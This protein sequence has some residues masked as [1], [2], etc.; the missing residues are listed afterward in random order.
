MSLHGLCT[1]A[2][3]LVIAVLAHTAE[4][5]STPRR[6][7]IQE[8]FPFHPTQSRLALHPDAERFAL[9]QKNHKPAADWGGVHCPTIQ[10]MR[11]LVDGY[12]ATPHP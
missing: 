8:K 6:S 10:Q 4:P 7:A 1:T 9:L 3:V 5:Q 11:D 12:L 2:A